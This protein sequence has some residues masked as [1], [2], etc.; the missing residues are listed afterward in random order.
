MKTYIWHLPKDKARGKSRK[1]LCGQHKAKHIAGNLEVWLSNNVL[2]C[3]K[4]LKKRKLTRIDRL[5]I[6]SGI[7]Y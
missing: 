6:K 7:I 4:C 2:I 1:P 3:E 5:I